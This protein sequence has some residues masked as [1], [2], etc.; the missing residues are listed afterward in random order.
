[1]GRNWRTSEMV[2]KYT[3]NDVKRLIKDIYD[4]CKKVLLNYPKNIFQGYMKL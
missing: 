4:D 1:M 2:S 3:Y